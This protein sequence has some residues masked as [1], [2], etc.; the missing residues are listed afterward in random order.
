[1]QYVCRPR[2]AE[3]HDF[4]GYMGRIE[5]GEIAIGDEVQ[6]L[7]SGRTTRVRDIRLL[8]RS[9]AAGRQRALGDTAAGGRGRHLARRH[10]RQGG[11]GRRVRQADRGHGVL[12]GGRPLEPGRKYVV[13][14]TTRET[15]ALVAAIE[16]RQDIN[17]LKRSR[18]AGW[19]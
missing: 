6:V 9:P 2:T 18:A 15:K 14:H 11:R 4:R 5:S 16:Y 12:A 3:H 13:R 19:R 1:V 8:D 10:D 7:P 17:E